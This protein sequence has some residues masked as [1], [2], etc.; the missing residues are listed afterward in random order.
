M[1]RAD[2]ESKMNSGPSPPSSHK[3]SVSTFIYADLAAWNA[4]T[5][6]FNCGHFSTLWFVEPHK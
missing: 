1:Q 2:P 5:A 3:S 6:V 4:S